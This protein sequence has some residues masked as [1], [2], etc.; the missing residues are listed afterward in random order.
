MNGSARIRRYRPGEERLLFAVHYSAIHQVARRDYAPEQLHAWAPAEPDTEHWENRIRRLNPF[1]AE[2]GDEIV[3]YADLQADGY[4]DHF[5]VSGSHPRLGIG[6]LLMNHLLAE[7]AALGLAELRSDVS[8]TAQPFFEKFGFT[9]VE[10]RQPERRGV[11]IP[12]ARMRRSSSPSTHP[13]LF[14]R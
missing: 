7:A 1:V 2:L 5:F 13:S 8:R 14:A 9:V 11:I 4:I 10:Y 3:G 6:S 12:N